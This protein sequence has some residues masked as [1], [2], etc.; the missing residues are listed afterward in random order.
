MSHYWCSLRLWKSAIFP[1]GS[2]TFV[3]HASS[4]RQRGESVIGLTDRRPDVCVSVRRMDQFFHCDVSEP[5]DRL[6]G[7]QSPL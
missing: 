7:I 2:F 1:S 6:T 5:D 3:H 4:I